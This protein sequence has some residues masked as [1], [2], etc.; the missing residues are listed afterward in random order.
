MLQ[1]AALIEIEG[2]V[3]AV[4]LA[5]LGCIASHVAALPVFSL[6]TCH[7]VLWPHRCLAGC[8]KTMWR[9]APSQQAWRQGTA[10]SCARRHRSRPLHQQGP[11]RLLQG[12]PLLTAERG[13]KAASLAAHRRVPLPLLCPLR[14]QVGVLLPAPLPQLCWMQ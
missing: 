8:C 5:C 4:T 13:Q 1:M 14:R 11:R 6:A 9:C 12:W 2:L 3:N 7:A 10:C